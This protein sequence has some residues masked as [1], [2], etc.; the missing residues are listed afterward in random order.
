MNNTSFYNKNVIVFSL[1]IL[2]TSISFLLLF[3]IDNSKRVDAWYNSSWTYRR[4]V[5]VANS[6]SELTNEDILLSLDTASLIS[7]GK[8]QSDCDDIRVIDSDDTAAISYW[9]EG[10]CN[11]A[12]TQIWARVPT[13]PSGGKTIY[14]YYGNSSATNSEQSWSGKFILMNTSAC[15]TGWT[16]ESSS[17][18]DF[19]QVFPKGSSSYGTTGGYSSHTHPDITLTTS[20]PSQSDTFYKKN[21]TNRAD[22]VHTHSV[23]FS[24][25]S[26]TI[27]PPYL[28]MLFCSNTNL[29]INTN[30]VALFDSSLPFGF[31]SFSALNNAFPRGNSTYTGTQAGSDIHAHTVNSATTGQP[32]SI[33]IAVTHTLSTGV[34]ASGAYH[35]H[36]VNTF[37][38]S[39]NTN[40]PPYV[41]MIYGQASSSTISPQS[42]ILMTNNIPPLGW[43]QFSSLNGNYPYGSSSYGTTGG[44]LTHS[45]SLSATIPAS[46]T[47]LFS[48]KTGNPTDVSATNTHTHTISGTLQSYSNEPPYRE[49]IFIKKKTSQSTTVNSEET[50]QGSNTPSFTNFSNNGPVNPG[51]TVTFS[52]TSIDPNSDNVFLV[53]CKTQGVTGTACDGGS[54]DTWCT[55][56]Q[57]AS[58]PSCGFSVPSVF[59]DDTYN[60]YPYVFDSNNEPAEGAYQGVLSTFSVNNTA[61]SVSAVTINSGNAITLESNN[62][63]TV[64]LTA[65]VSDN[66]SCYGTEITSVLGYVYRS[67]I[68]YSGCDSS[69]EADNN[70]CYPE[71]TCSVVSGSCTDT[72]DAS[73]N[74]TCSVDIY[75]Y[76]DPTVTSTQYPDETWKTT[77][78]AT[79]DDSS[80]ASTEVS[81][82][83]EMNALIAYSISSSINYGTLSVEGKNDPLDR[84]T[85]TTPTGNVGL[86]HEV[87]GTNMCTDY[88]TCSA[89]TIA[90][91]YQKYA[92]SSSTS[93]SSA[94]ALSGTATEVEININKPTSGS[95]PTKNLWW[96]I[97]IPPST[98]PGVYTGNINVT[99]LMAEI[100][101]WPY[102]QI[103][104]PTPYPGLTGDYH[105]ELMGTNCVVD[106]SFGALFNHTDPN[107]TAPYFELEF[108][109][110]TNKTESKTAF[111][112]VPNE[113]ETRYTPLRLNFTLPDAD[114]QWWRIRLWDNYGEVSPW[115]DYTY[116]NCCPWDVVP[117]IEDAY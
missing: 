6:G 63:K 42:I 59:P 94:T 112:S 85:T 101:D 58:N 32:S 65:T 36:S 26:Q 86:D 76:A 15:D 69:G 3:S 84:T 48:L 49:T 77:I 14:V 82:G 39:S 11:S 110:I 113:G 83:V 9:I 60:V 54:G 13:L 115:S 103:L 66:N 116:F 1:V 70:N 16:T 81:S 27:L 50:P 30:D 38:S 17:G 109:P 62:T 18:G 97:Q 106:I 117:C 78:K 31:S 102:L 33:S 87:S 43:S 61:P 75:S 46:S 23:T 7:A 104:T 96:G 25:Q 37:S 12:S 67:G 51:S 93:Y 73:A 45:H 79:D 71:I 92:L 5:S 35:T 2:L 74:Y 72:S 55:S 21:G 8:M 100:S 111:L 47:A 22:E 40:L 114:Y 91:G 68:G 19:Y 64:T 44:A 107:A 108:S 105:I 29:T 88:P 98:N 80:S 34:D 41:S 57:V 24:I 52:A 99:G 20:G 95:P 4:S 89:S 90:V 28:D 53:V 56:S 10:G